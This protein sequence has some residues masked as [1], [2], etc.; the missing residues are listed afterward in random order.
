MNKKTDFYLGKHLSLHYTLVRYCWELS[1]LPFVVV[2][3]WRVLA[4]WLCFTIQFTYKGK[5]D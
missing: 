4:G 3:S 1:L 2:D 5:E